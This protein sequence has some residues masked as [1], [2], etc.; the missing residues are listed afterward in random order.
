MP[1]L[2]RKIKLLFAMGPVYLLTHSTHP[3]VK[4]SVVAKQ[5]RKV[6]VVYEINNLHMSSMLIFKKKLM[7]K[8]Y[9]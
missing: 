2:A 9:T 1:Q 4:L 8:S 7:H 3:A 6:C 5:L